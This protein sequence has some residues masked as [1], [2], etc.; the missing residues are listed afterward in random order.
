MPFLLLMPSFNQARYIREA[1]ESVLRQDDPDWELWIVDNSTDATPEVMAEYKDPRI[2]FHHIP[3]RMDP[4]SCLNW[5][6][7]RAQGRDFS[8][9]HTDNNLRADYVSAFRAALSAD[10]LSL[11]YC[12]MR[13]MDG[14]GQRTGVF[15]RGVFDLSR[16]LSLSPLGV[17]F[18]ATTELARKLGGFSCGDAADDVLFCI[19]AYGFGTWTHLP[20]PLIDYRI[21][22]GSRTEEYGGAAKIHGIFLRTFAK[23]IPELEARGFRPKE[24][25]IQALRRTRLDIRLAAEDSVL[26]SRHVGIRWW[27]G[28]D[29]FDGLWKVGMLSLP[30]FKSEEGGP[31]RF[32]V[33]SK[34]GGKRYNPM[35]LGRLRRRVKGLGGLLSSCAGTFHTLVVSHAY[36][37]LGGE[38]VTLR[39][40]SS[41]AMTLWAC[42]LL[43]R[44]LGWTIELDQPAPSGIPW[45]LGSGPATAWIDLSGKGR[46]P[47]GVPSIVW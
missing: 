30:W 26:G 20:D 29:Y 32:S 11:A 42:R 23:A 22:E 2:K 40:G 6:L 14:S 1:V 16:L 37:S 25:M 13:V 8:Y 41:D 7:E 38:G 45:T 21:H 36:L 19:R 27:G 10:P 34:L 46:A 18:A 15:R 5:M 31:K 39:A 24:M 4:G 44:D 35:A 12:D 33:F 43:S 28:E 17:P 9:V 3:E 47:E